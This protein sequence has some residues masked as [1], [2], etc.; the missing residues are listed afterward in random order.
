MRFLTEL[1][2]E[3]SLHMQMLSRS[4]EFVFMNQ[5]QWWF[6]SSWLEVIFFSIIFI[7]FI[8]L[9]IW[10]T[11]NFFNLKNKI[12]WNYCLQNN[13]NRFIGRC[14]QIRNG[15]FTIKIDLFFEWNHLRNDIPSSTSNCSSRSCLQKYFGLFFSSILS[16]ILIFFW[17][18][19]F[20]DLACRNILV[21]FFFHFYLECSFSFGILVLDIVIQLFSMIFMIQ[22]EINLTNIFYCSY[23][24]TTLQRLL[25]ESHIS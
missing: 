1:F 10:Q 20:W 7:Q 16:S 12:F 21:C 8:H 18:S 25:W 5:S 4:R 17:N 13:L 3:I 19:S 23:Q 15:N 11:G 6:L 24:K 14:L 2:W 9:K 22:Q